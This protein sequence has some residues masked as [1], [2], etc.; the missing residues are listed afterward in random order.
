[1]PLTT[2]PTPGTKKCS[3]ISNS[4]GSSSVFN[5]GLIL[6]LFLITL[7][8]LINCGIPYK[9]TLET[10]KIGHIWPELS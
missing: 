3:C 8:N 6:S 7:I 5:Y 9:V 2:N 10:I 1:M 4:K